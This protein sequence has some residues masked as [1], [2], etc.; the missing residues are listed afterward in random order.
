[1][2]NGFEVTGSD[3]AERLARAL[4]NADVRTAASSALYG[5]GK[6]LI[7]ATRAAARRRL[8][9]RGG[10]AARVAR[11]PQKIVDAGGTDAGIRIVVEK[12]TGAAAANEGVVRHPVFGKRKAWAE[13][14]VTPGWFDD[15]LKAA[16]PIVR[17]HVTKAMETVA[18][19]LVREVK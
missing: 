13:Q 5:A 15:P 11:A 17:P 3:K 4:R 19:Q 7:E 1:M 6:Q 8:P 14:K 16:G 10:L 2:S 9:K 18:E 12:T